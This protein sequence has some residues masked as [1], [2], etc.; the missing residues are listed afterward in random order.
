MTSERSTDLAAGH[1][2]GARVLP[3]RAL[4]GWCVWFGLAGGALFAL[5]ATRYLAVAPLASGWSAR[6]FSV[7]M[8]AAQA[9]LLGAAFALVLVLVA[10]LIPRPRAV[11]LAGLVLGGAALTLAWIDTLVYQQYRFHLDA[12]VWNLVSGGAAEETFVFS[13]R[14]YAKLAA[15]ALGLCALLGLAARLAWSWASSR[16]L[17]R[18]R[19]W[20]G[21]TLVVVVC[22]HSALCVWATAAAYVPITRQARILP[23]YKQVSAR[24]FMRRI[25]VQV[26]RAELVHDDAASSLVYPRAPLRCSPPQRPLDVLLLVIDSW[27]ADALDARATPRLA[28]FA[29]ECLRFENHS[30]CGNATRIGMFSLFYGLPGTYWHDV[31]A[32]R[33]GAALVQ[34]F[35]HAGYDVRA[36][37][38]AP[39][40][41]PEFDVTIFSEIEGLRLESEGATPAE[42]DIDATDD[43]VAW[44]GQRDSSRPTLALL[45]WDAPHAYDMPADFPLE[46]R[47]SLE[48]VD[49]L[50]L[51]PDSDPVPFR[52]R[53]LNSVRFVDGLAGRA[54][55]ALRA[56]GR[57][58]HTLVIVTGD[59]GQEFNDLGQNY[60]GHNSNFAPPQVHVPFLMRWPGQE[61]RTF[62]HATS[63]FDVAPTVLERV[64]ACANPPEDFCAGRSLFDTAPR[65][66]LTMATYSDFAAVLP[67]ER[68]VVVRASGELEAFDERYEPSELTERD[69][70]SLREALR[71][72]THFRCAAK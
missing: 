22:V 35:A 29:R 40:F 72:R 46:F 45:F 71:Q 13:S 14:S 52:N 57:L 39:L 4:F 53:Y 70:E 12:S 51:G 31:L 27:R 23:L 21:L 9:S 17:R 63:H 54:L 1:A 26:A 50:A 25:G 15:I 65:G 33:R 19:R 66:V 67:G 32:E 43:F 56:S 59:H 62:T 28:E 61:A 8:F 49:Y 3:R 64:L 42:R 37:R 48:T 36:F 5:V 16:R 24:S 69:R 18:A 10:A 58:D 47:P 30:S 41:S 6:A 7:L 68:Y 44:L 20:T 34:Q 60:W 11:T 2:F 38:S 55:D